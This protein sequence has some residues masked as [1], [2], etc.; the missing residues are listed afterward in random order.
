[1]ILIDLILE[2]IQKCPACGNKDGHVIGHMD[3]I[4]EERLFFFKCGSGSECQ[5]RWRIYFNL[6][7]SFEVTLA[8]TGYDDF[9]NQ[10]PEE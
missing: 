9:Y 4:D 3:A 7:E 10:F 8:L 1:M 5:D 2:E 6:E